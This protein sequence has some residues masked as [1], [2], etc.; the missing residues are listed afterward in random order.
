VLRR[1]SGPKRDKVTGDWRKLC[2]EELN[3]Y[4][5]YLTNIFR[6]IKLR[7]MRWLGHV[8]LWRRVEVYTGYWWRNLRERTQMED[9][10]VSGR[11]I[12]RRIF[13]KWDLR[14]WTGSI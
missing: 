6:V 13:R 5:Y 9:P 2:N 11:I 14:A 4:L 1:I 3:Y 10:G 12:L 7:K 8:A